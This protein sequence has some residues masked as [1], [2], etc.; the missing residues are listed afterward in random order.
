MPEPFSYIRLFSPE[1]KRES[2]LQLRTKVWFEVRLKDPHCLNRNIV[3]SRISL[4]YNQHF[5]ADQSAQVSHFADNET[6]ALGK[7]LAQGHLAS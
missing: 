3:M 4:I 1:T 5:R 2:E 6:K 7:M